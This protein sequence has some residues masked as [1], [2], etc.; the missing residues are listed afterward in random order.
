MRVSGLSEMDAVLGELGKSTGKAV[1]RRTLKTSAQ[2]MAD[3]AN[4]LAPVLSGDLSTSFN[5]STKLNKRQGRMH[6]KMFKNDKATVE[7]FVGSSDPAALQQEFGNQNHG[8]QPSLRP[9][10]DRDKVPLVNRIGGILGTEIDKAAL[11]AARKAARLANL[12]GK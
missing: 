6:R 8:P 5:Y 9:A 12:A 11:R 7:G 4:S 1:M 10:W 3:I 2:P